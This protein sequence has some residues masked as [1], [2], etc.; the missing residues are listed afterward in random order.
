M[1]VN[2]YAEE[3][4]GESQIVEKK[5]GV[6]TF[7]GIRMILKSHKALHYG[8][9]DDDRSAVT[10]WCP[11]FEGSGN[12]PEILLRCLKDMQYEVEKYAARFHTS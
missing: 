3:L 6:N 12:H 2:I 11:F 4:T 8:P 7:F 9:N 10:I 5:V 1:R